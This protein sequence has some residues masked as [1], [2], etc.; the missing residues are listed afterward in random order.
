M[1]GRQGCRWEESW[2]HYRHSNSPDGRCEE[3]G[4]QPSVVRDQAPEVSGA[5]LEGL[6]ASLGNSDFIPG[7]VAA[8]VHE[9]RKHPA[10]NS[11]RT[12]L[13]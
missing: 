12:T 8:G 1:S 4:G 3:Q 13:L 9:N 11:G 5:R 6:E 10:V 2:E 7:P